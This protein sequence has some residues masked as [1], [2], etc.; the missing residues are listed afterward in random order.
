MDNIYTENIYL[1]DVLVDR[2]GRLKPSSILYIA[3]E[4]A[5]Q[6]CI[7]L[8][9][10]YDT[11]IQKN[12]FWAVTRH[13]VAI[14]RL[15]RR[16]ETITVETWPMPTSRVA[17]PR[18]TAA[19]DQEGH[20]LFQSV[21]LWVLMDMTSRNM[22]LPGK[23]GVKVDGI[24][25]GTELDIPHSI[26][27]KDAENCC[28]RTVTYDFLDRNGHMNNTRYMDWVYDL[29]NSDFLSAHTA[30]AFTIC[31]LNEAREDQNIHLHWILSEDHVLQVDAT[32]DNAECPQKQ[33]RVFSA[34]VHFS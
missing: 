34:Q 8:G 33:G 17:Y 14:A 18:A 28:Q 29:L 11:L 1:S 25:Q 23:S 9:V 32:R 16:G 2:Y 13:K 21:S 27:P 30:K 5:S 4:V 10:D 20:L 6:H 19:Y 22:V 26:V 24:L 7:A 15:P 12:L 3:Q 31:Y